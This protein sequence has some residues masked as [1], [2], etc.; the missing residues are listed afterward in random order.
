MAVS[1]QVRRTLDELSAEFNELGYDLTFTFTYDQAKEIETALMDLFVSLLQGSLLAVAVLL[2]F[3]RDWSMI[4]VIGMTIP[5]AVI[6]AFA[7]LYFAGLSINLMTLG[8][9]A[10]AAGML[11]DNAIVVSENIY[12]HIQLGANSL[13]AS[14]RGATR[15]AEPYGPQP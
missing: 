7:L 3:L 5:V 11:V 15:L 9:L 12:R 8:A 2:L 6:A 4:V 10:L 1:R 13:E 14:T